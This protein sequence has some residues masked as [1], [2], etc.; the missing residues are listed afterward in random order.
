MTKDSLV[1][2]GHLPYYGPECSGYPDWMESPRPTRSFWSPTAQSLTRIGQFLVSEARKGRLTKQAEEV[3]QA[4]QK[5]PTSFFP[6]G[7]SNR[8]IMWK[9]SE[10]FTREVFWATHMQQASQDSCPQLK[11]HAEPT[12][13]DLQLGS[14]QQLPF[15]SKRRTA[16]SATSVGSSPGLVVTAVRN[17]GW[18]LGLALANLC[19]THDA[20]PHGV[21]I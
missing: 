2:S 20:Q 15:L 16:Q 7:P 9:D 12:F 3:T 11:A 8:R 14:C 5:T 6:C 21:G 1:Q 17:F 4:Q 10:G 13:C 19:V 18:P